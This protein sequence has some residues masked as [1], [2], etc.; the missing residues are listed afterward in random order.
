M[1]TRRWYYLIPLTANLADSFTRSSGTT[2]TNSRER[3]SCTPGAKSWSGLTQLL[4][5]VERVAMEYSPDCA[6]PYISR[7][8]AGTA[9]SVRARGVEI[10]SSGDLVQQFE[11]SWTP[12]QLATHRR[13]SEA[14]YRIKDRAF[15]AAALALR[16][17][18]RLSESHLQQQMAAWFVEEG[19]VTDSAPVVAIASNAGNPHYLP[20]A[21]QSRPIVPD[22]VLLLDLWGQMRRR[23]A[24][25]L[26]TSH[27]WALPGRGCRTK[28]PERFA[29]SSTPGTLRS[30]SCESAA[31]SGA[32]LRGW[33]VDRAARE[34]LER[35][36]MADQILHRTGHSLGESVHGN[37]AHMD[38]FETHDD[39]RLLPGDRFYGG[40]RA[41]FFRLWRTY[42]GQRV[43]VGA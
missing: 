18:A 36:D 11:A 4:A 37:G 2:S 16:T 22:E 19:L 21:R 28:R 33:Q 3:K 27:G 35:A 26:R 30:H 41:L 13:A 38:D 39:R 23:Q 42:R 43:P 12:E 1:T 29:P 9:E 15:E 25:C 8:D 20:T 10:I 31:R 32:E 6:I 34:V 24:R 40:A 7:L 14:L 5:G 17:G